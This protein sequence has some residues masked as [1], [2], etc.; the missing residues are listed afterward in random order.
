MPES[1]NQSLHA[2]VRCRIK[3]FQNYFSL[4]RRPSEIIPFQRA[5][6]WLKMPSH[7]HF[8]RRAILNC[9]ID[10]TK[11]VLACRQGSLVGL[12]MQDYKSLHAAVTI[13]FTL[14]N[15]QTDRQH[16]DQLI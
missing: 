13:C 2:V 16:F 9:K 11:Q 10:H 1:I 3:L 7:A 12:C 15:I 14:V 5:K 4:R 8:F 6:T